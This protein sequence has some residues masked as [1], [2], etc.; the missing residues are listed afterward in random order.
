MKPAPG[1]RFAASAA[2]WFA[3]LLARLVAP[4]DVTHDHLAATALTNGHVAAS[5]V[6]M[7]PVR[8]I[9]VATVLDSYVLSEL[10]RPVHGG[11]CAGNARN[12]G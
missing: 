10:H 4:P 2:A 12:S 6:A 8:A 1:F 5:F 9:V 11:R 3:P 7:T